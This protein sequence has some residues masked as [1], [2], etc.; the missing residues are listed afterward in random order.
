MRINAAYRLSAE[1]KSEYIKRLK[2]MGLKHLGKGVWSDVFQHPTMK[3]VAVKVSVWDPGFS[4]YTEFCRAHTSNPYLIKILDVHEQP[5]G[6]GFN[7]EGIYGDDPGAGGRT[8]SI[9]TFVE[10][11]VP[12]TET[13]LSNFV[14]SCEELAGF[15]L[16]GKTFNY[17]QAYDREDLNQKLW[18]ELARQSK[19]KNLQQFAAWYVAQINGSRIP[20]I[21]DD[22]VM[23]RHNQIVFSDPLS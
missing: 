14:A 22:N 8:S 11:L 2:E 21:H 18:R 1:R 3:D 16:T 9:I 7:F 12:V 15:K 17:Y 20:D 10:K 23:M 4:A 13:A 19:D 5:M 6:K